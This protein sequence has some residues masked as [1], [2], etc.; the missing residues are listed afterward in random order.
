MKGD[1]TEAA[2]RRKQVSRVS[3]RGGQDVEFTVD[4]NSQRLKR[5]GR[6]VNT[7]MPVG[8]RNRSPDRRDEI[9]SRPQGLHVT[10]PDNRTRNP[11]RISLFTILKDDIG[12]F[13]F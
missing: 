3:E 8:C 7:P 4:G 11:A 12:E 13:R 6:K 5:A 1:D 10:S 9:G 2:P